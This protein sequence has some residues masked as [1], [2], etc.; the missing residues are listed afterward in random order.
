MS[1]FLA[2]KVIST[3][4]TSVLIPLLASLE[5]HTFTGP[6]GR[7]GTQGPGGS[8]PASDLKEPKRSGEIPGGKAQSHRLPTLG[9]SLPERPDRFSKDSTPPPGPPGAPPLKEAVGGL[10]PLHPGLLSG[11]REQSRR[12]QRPRLRRGAG[13]RVNARRPA[14]QLAAPSTQLAEWSHADSGQLGA[15]HPQRRR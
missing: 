5:S 3:P 4:E 6:E 12:Q 9:G 2:S 14:L 8:R 1:P 10:V 11:H 13:P 7:P 15:S